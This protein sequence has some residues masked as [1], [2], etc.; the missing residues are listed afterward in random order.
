MLMKSLREYLLLGQKSLKVFG[1][2][3]NGKFIGQVGEK[4]SV[5]LRS[6]CLYNWLRSFFSTW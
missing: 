5:G 1:L 2:F 4:R 3:G 6:N